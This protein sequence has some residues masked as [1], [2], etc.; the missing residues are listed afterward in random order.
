VISLS[1]SSPLC[2]EWGVRLG[3]NL[4]SS[5]SFARAAFDSEEEGFKFDARG[6]ELGFVTNGIEIDCFMDTIRDGHI[7]RGYV[8]RR[9]VTVGDETQCFPEGTYLLPGGVRLVGVKAGSYAEIHRFNDWMRLGVPFH[10]GFTF[11]TGEA[12]RVD[13]TIDFV[14]VDPNNP[15]SPLG[16]IARTDAIKVAGKEIVN[17]SRS[18]FPVFDLGLALRVRTASW[19]EA[20]I[21]VRVQNFRFP[22]LA[23]GM[24]FGKSE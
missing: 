17:G 19:A 12:T 8:D 21:G 22:A 24:I 6:I 5:P 4:G 11:F 1:L 15:E 7:N 3:G 23:W 16:V 18:P 14:P 10:I 9:C 20:E 13:S 2:A